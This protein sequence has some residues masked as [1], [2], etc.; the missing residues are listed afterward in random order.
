MNAKLC[1]RHGWLASCAAIKQLA[2]GRPKRDL[3]YK[4]SPG[5]WDLV[6]CVRCGHVYHPS[7]AYS[8][9]SSGHV[10]GERIIR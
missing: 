1:G 9:G 6:Q 8:G 3:E 10:S 7:H 5:T 4:F 2:S